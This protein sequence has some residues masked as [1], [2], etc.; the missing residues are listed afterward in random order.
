MGIESVNRPPKIL[1]ARNVWIFTL[2]QTGK[3]V[4]IKKA[5]FSAKCK[6]VHHFNESS[7]LFFLLF[8][9]LNH[10]FMKKQDTLREKRTNPLKINKP[11]CKFFW[12]ILE[13]KNIHF[14]NWNFKHLSDI[15]Y[16]LFFPF[17]ST[18]CFVYF[19]MAFIL[20]PASLLF[21][22]LFP[23]FDISVFI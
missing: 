17:L 8:F 4:S 5:K 3:Y 1:F 6:N 16:I 14:V 2:T 12:H 11:K 20:S 18:Y 19:T 21:V 22:F 13:E 10:S 9:I 23:I 7:C 15:T